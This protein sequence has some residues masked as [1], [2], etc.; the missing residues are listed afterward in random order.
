MSLN[1][2]S[3]DSGYNCGRLLALIESAQL[4]HHGGK[5]PGTTVVDRYYGRASSAPGLV[6]GS[7]MAEYQIW[8][9]GIDNRGAAYRIDEAVRDVIDKLGDAFPST[10]TI[11]QQGRFALGYYHQKGKNALDARQ[12]AQASTEPAEQAQHEAAEE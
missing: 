7:M 1:E 2:N 8:R 5:E 4:K 3:E 12:H 10:L 9:S 11:E 6:F